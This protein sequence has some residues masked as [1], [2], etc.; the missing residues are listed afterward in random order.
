MIRPNEVYVLLCNYLKG[1]RPVFNCRGELV[2][3]PR[4]EADQRSLEKLYKVLLCYSQEIKGYLNGDEP[5][6]WIRLAGGIKM[7]GNGSV[8]S[9][10][11]LALYEFTVNVFYEGIYGFWDFVIERKNIAFKAVSF[12]FGGTFWAVP[13]GKNFENFAGF[14]DPNDPY[15]VYA[16][17]DNTIELVRLPG[18]P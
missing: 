1:A 17:S 18:L 5:S 12:Y 14:L 3:S 9:E 11:E 7:E 13:K 2:L 15:P 8:L 4:R 16:F 6:P 10:E